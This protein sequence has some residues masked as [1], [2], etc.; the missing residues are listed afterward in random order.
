MRVLSVRAISFGPFSDQELELAPGF[1]LIW[2]GNEAG[3]SSWHAAIQLG[4]CGMKRARGRRARADEALVQRHQPWGRADWKVLVLVEL[5]DGNVLEV[6]QDLADPAG[7]KI[8]DAATGRDLTSRYIF[9]GSADASGVLGLNRQIFGGTVCVRQAE[10]LEVLSHPEDFQEQLQKA[11]IA[12]NSDAT[13]E[14]ALRCVKE[15]RSENVGMRRRG[16]SKP[17]PA[18]VEQL[19]STESH[20]EM[21]RVEHERFLQLLDDLSE[22]EE[23]VVRLQRAYDEARRVVLVA[24]AASLSEKVQEIRVLQSQFPDGAPPTGDSTSDQRRS[25]SDVLATWRGRSMPVPPDSGPSA[26]DI[27]QEL[28][29]LPFPPQGDTEVAPEV[30]TALATYDSCKR[31]LEVHRNQSFRPP[32]EAHESGLPT[33]PELRVY[34]ESLERLLPDV[35]S[36]LERQLE[37]LREAGVQRRKAS[38]AMAS[39][40][41]TLVVLAIVLFSSG[42]NPGAGASAIAGLLTGAATA[43]LL[44]AGQSG[45]Q[46]TSSLATRLEV[47]RDRR[48]E[49]ESA[50]E[51]ARRRLAANGLPTAPQDLRRLASA[52][53]DT[54]L[55]QEQYDKWKLMEQQYSRAFEDAAHG[56]RKE[57]LQRGLDDPRIEDL[58]LRQLAV[59][60]AGQCRTNRELAVLAARRSD[61]AENLELRR[62][63]EEAYAQQQGRAMRLEQKLVQAARRLGIDG[64]P[65]D[66]LAGKLEARLLQLDKQDQELDRSREAFERLCGLLGPSSLLELEERLADYERELG[67]LPWPS[68][69]PGPVGRLQEAADRSDV[70]LREAQN[71]AE[72]LKGKIQEFESAKPDVAEAE[73]QHAAA[74]AD[75]ERLEELDAILERTATFLAEAKDEIQRDIAPRLSAIISRHIGKATSERYVDA[76]I[77]P[78]SLEIQ[79]QDADGQWRTAPHLSHGTAEQIYLLLRLALAETLVTTEEIA[80]VFLDD[81]TVHSDADRTQAILDLL[82]AESTQRQVILFSQEEEVLAWAETR[83]RRQQ[84]LLLR[85][86]CPAGNGLEGRDEV[87]EVLQMSRTTR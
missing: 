82:L 59:D 14:A 87:A 53:D 70:R 63:Q 85:I 4:L 31:E 46:R 17:L 34:A 47:Q 71:E 58:D 61:L 1:T 67:P 66:S 80:P 6:L 57:L 76:R 9:E 44:L 86:D 5:D 7:S 38:W 54:H 56:L 74:R 78:A 16:S 48:T 64:E 20:L 84:N 72:Q 29:S 11:A 77:D 83:L 42:T 60:Y 25:I 12:G 27:E 19:R 62:R 13:A 8:T 45:Q 79:A 41:T 32:V 65:G 26:A 2:G 49:V 75:L 21:A 51:D 24:K 18:A 69:P 30:E 10:L 81:V 33:G 22:S 35:D 39:F 37:D 43:W 40:T 15:F 23:D 68:V 52:V 28:A 3:K 55:Q 73:E 50:Q 36:E